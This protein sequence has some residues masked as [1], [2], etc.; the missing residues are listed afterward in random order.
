MAKKYFPSLEKTLPHSIGVPIGVQIPSAVEA[1]EPAPAPDPI[2]DVRFDLQY[3][4]DNG[5]M[6]VHLQLRQSYIRSLLTGD[7]HWI[8]LPSGSHPNGH[9]RYLSVANIIVLHI[10][11]N[12]SAE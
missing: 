2:V 1:S 6:R 3:S 9:A 5:D 4:M 11:G 10:I 7:I 8:P 12:F